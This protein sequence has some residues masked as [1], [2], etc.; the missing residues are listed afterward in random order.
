MGEAEWPRKDWS[1]SGP[2][3]IGASFTKLRIVPYSEQMRLVNITD[4]SCVGKIFS[5]VLSGAVQHSN[6]T[7]V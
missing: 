7:I 5:A 1:Q 3:G 4:N 6:I 2:K